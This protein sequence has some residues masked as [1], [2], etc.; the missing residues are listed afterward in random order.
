MKKK[1]LVAG[2]LFLFTICV[3]VYAY[4]YKDH[5]DIASEDAAYRVSVKKLQNEFLVNPLESNRKYLDKSIEV[6]GVI[7][8]IDSSSHS[9]VVDGKLSVVFKDSV[10]NGL[11][12]QKGIVLKGRFLGYD[13]LLEELKMDQAVLSE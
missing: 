2:S 7:T 1:L 9:I 10:L 6:F 5:R 8:T 3:G 12:L 13:D 11:F 4:M